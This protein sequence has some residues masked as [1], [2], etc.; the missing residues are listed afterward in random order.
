MESEFFYS[1]YLSRP[2]LLSDD[3]F[4]EYPYD[5][6]SSLRGASNQMISEIGTRNLTKV[7]RESRPCL[8]IP[9]EDQSKGWNYLSEFSIHQ[10]DKLVV[11]HVRDSAYLAGVVPHHDWSYHDFRDV[12]IE[13]YRPCIEDLITKGYK[14]VRIGAATNQ[15]LQLKSASFIDLCR[16]RCPDLGDFI[17][18][19]LLSVCDFFICTYSGPFGI[20]A[21]FDTP[22]IAV[23]AAPLAQPYPKH[24]HVI[25]K[26]LYHG[27]EVVSLIDIGNGMRLGDQESTPI[28]S[29]YS[30]KELADHGYHYE[31]NSEVD[32]QKGVA[33]FERR[34]VGGSFIG[35]LT[36]MQ[37]SFKNAVSA[38]FWGDEN[39]NA[40]CTSFINDHPDA[41][42]GLRAD[43]DK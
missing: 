16:D 27:D 8:E 21:L 22:M 25:P 30:G 11:L 43:A 28:S 35:D 20:G 7:Y 2:L 15:T 13:T 32:I 14:V 34:L 38:E 17:D 39:N 36:R 6:H 1:L 29:C 41:F 12:D 18:V 10:S 3:S 26:L 33:E 23:N 5:L 19:F 42:T 31:D 40:I 37:C 24:C 4:A 9:K